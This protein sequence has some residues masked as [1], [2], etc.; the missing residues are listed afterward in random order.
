MTAMQTGFT[1]MSPAEFIQCK[2]C[3]STIPLILSKWSPNDQ[4][5][6][7]KRFKEVSGGKYFT[8]AEIAE[9]TD[10]KWVKTPYTD[11]IK[12]SD[13]KQLPQAKRSALRCP[14]CGNMN[15]GSFDYAP[16]PS[17]VVK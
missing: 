10:A 8:G 2:Q 16:E 11:W 9:I 3:Q 5:R 4:A 15:P 1:P 6:W 12:G 14:K 13:F 7:G 17:G